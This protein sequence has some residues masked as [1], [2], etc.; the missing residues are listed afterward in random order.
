MKR[1]FMM[2]TGILSAVTGGLGIL[3]AIGLFAASFYI[4]EITSG[5]NFL[6]V[7]IG[8][9]DT[10][11]LVGLIFVSFYILAFAITQLVLGIQ[12]AKKSNDVNYTSSGLTIAVL[13]ISAFFGL[14]LI[15]VA[16]AIVT[17]CLPWE[18]AAEAATA[19]KTSAKGHVK[20]ENISEFDQAVARLKQYKTDGVI[21][22]EAFEAKMKELVEKHTKELIKEEN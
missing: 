15:S 5:W 2:V 11:L 3:G 19:G 22:E 4:S 8:G 20:K 1:T 16:L 10:A 13:I 9:Y 6:G 7:Y 18:T 21:T 17:L 12:L 14:G